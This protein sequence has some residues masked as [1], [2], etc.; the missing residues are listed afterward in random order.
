MS[1]AVTDVSLSLCVFATT[2]LQAESKSETSAHRPGD[3]ETLQNGVVEYFIFPDLYDP[4]FE[5]PCVSSGFPSME[6]TSTSREARETGAVAFSG[7]T[8]LVS[9]C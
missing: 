4:V 9:P 7:G 8:L 1:P 2:L 3:E 6:N 5:L